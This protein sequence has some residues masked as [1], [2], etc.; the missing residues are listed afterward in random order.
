MELKSADFGV[1]KRF[2]RRLTFSP[3]DIHSIF[4]NSYET[5]VFVLINPA[6]IDYHFSV[7]REGEPMASMEYHKSGIIIKKQFLYLQKSSY[8]SFVREKTR[9]LGNIE[10]RNRYCWN[11]PRGYQIRKNGLHRTLIRSFEIV[12]SSL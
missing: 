9:I 8:K 12:F 7:T 3:N 10:F 6:D 11:G 2:Q 4:I 1:V 5:G